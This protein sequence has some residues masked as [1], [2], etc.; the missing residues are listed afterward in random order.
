[1]KLLIGMATCNRIDLLTMSLSSL[2]ES[3]YPDDWLISI[4]DDCSDEFAL[5]DLI[6]VLPLRSKVTKNHQR[7]G[8]DAN[9]HNIFVDFLRTDADA[10]LI[11]DSDLIYDPSWHSAATNLISKTDGVLSLF[12]TYSHSSI[13][14]HGDLVEKQSI[15][16]A[17][18]ILTRPIVASI[19][20][21]VG[22]YNRCFDWRWSTFLRR[23]GIKIFCTTKSYVQ[24]IGWSGFNRREIGFDYGINFDPSTIANA[25]ILEKMF[26]DYMTDLYA[27]RTEIIESIRL[28]IFTSLDYRIGNSILRPAR[29][30]RSRA[31]ALLCY[32]H[33]P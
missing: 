4:Y 10:L 21:A 25:C 31:K 20:G 23:S 24:H 15:G 27:R 2:A 5:A 33:K 19:V 3:C 9:M 32:S 16:G 11:A 6:S 17:G 13:S 12:N 22:E 26:E 18:T 30:V 7:I 8:A 1:M 29:W 28:P 14:I